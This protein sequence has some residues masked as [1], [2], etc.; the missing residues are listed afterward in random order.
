MRAS[1]TILFTLLAFAG[2]GLANW[3][4]ARSAID[5]TP[6]KSGSASTLP[7]NSDSVIT[8][9]AR[10]IKLLQAS[11][12][13]LFSNNRKPW[14]PPDAA[15]VLPPSN[16]PELQPAEAVPL[17]ALAVPLPVVTLVGIQKT[18]KGSMALLSDQTG[19]APVWLKD[20][21][22]YQD[23]QVRNITGSSAD[24]ENGTT[25][26]TLELYPVIPSAAA[27]P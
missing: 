11:E 6:I 23:W 17:S 9:N 18:P 5:V 3:H 16:M 8:L 12:R 10:E 1:V 7:D 27:T 24:L 4:M 25:K 13:P 26:I 14:V 20:G 2:I 15:D 21:E 19:A 22:N